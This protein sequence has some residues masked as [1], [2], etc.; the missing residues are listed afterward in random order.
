MDF[1]F[2]RNCRRGEAIV[3]MINVVFLLLIFFL[4]SAQI[5]P[6]A[7]FD[8]SLPL[9]EG[10]EAEPPGDTLYI[11]NEGQ[12]AFNAVRGAAV[13]DALAERT[14]PDMPLQIRADAGLDAQILARLLPELARRGVHAVTLVARAR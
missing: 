1:S 4:M 8:V 14:M 13:Y 9:A 5:A 3:P 12:L 6:P 10:G 11:D 2:P 7:P